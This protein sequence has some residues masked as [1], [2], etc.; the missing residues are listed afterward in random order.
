ML[1][2]EVPARSDDSVP[3]PSLGG[4]ADVDTLRVGW[5]GPGS[6]PRAHPERAS[7]AHA[8][9]ATGAQTPPR[10]RIRNAWFRG[11]L[12]MEALRQEPATPVPASTDILGHPRGL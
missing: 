10:Q 3:G 4:G 12:L 8:G 11:D 9:S 5:T 6:Q 2:E 7:L 1:C